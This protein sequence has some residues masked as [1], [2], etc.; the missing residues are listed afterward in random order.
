MN[1]G[2]GC[3]PSIAARGSA[4]QEKDPYLSMNMYTH[5]AI[6]FTPRL[7]MYK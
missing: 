2:K 5:R 3:P 7:E 6:V 4:F 1:P